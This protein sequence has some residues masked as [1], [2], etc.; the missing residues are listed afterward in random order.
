SI[1][2]QD[3]DGDGL[4]NLQEFYAGL[5]PRSAQSFLRLTSVVKQGS[6]VQLSFPSASGRVY[7]LEGRG[8]LT[9]GS[10]QSLLDGIVGTGSAIQLSDAPGVT[11]RFYRVRVI[12]P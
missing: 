11:Q 12:P 6:G 7:R 2:N 4:T 3:T 10:W 8:G 1:A 9:S 5:D